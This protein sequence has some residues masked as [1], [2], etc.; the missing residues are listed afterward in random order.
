MV[1]RALRVESVR[2]CFAVALF[3]RSSSRTRCFSD[4]PT[5]AMLPV[6]AV[7]FD[8]AMNMPREGVA[9]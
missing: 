2:G 5:P 8:S 7:L 3:N 4:S 9:V 1:K 6:L